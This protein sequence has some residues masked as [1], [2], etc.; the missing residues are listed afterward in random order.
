LYAQIGDWPK[1]DVA[2]HRCIELAGTQN[3]PLSLEARGLLASVMQRQGKAL[4]G[5]A[6]ETAAIEL[7]RRSSLKHEE[8]E[9]LLKR[10][11]IQQALGHQTLAESDVKAAAALATALASWPLQIETA[12]AM[13]D[14]SLAVNAEDSVTSYRNALQLAESAG[15]REE[16]S[17][18]LAG[19]AR[20][21]QSEGQLEDAA[22]SIEKALRIVEASR[23]SLAS[24]ELQVTYFSMH[25]SW[26]ELAVDICM[27][28]DQKNPNKGYAMQA[29]AYTERARA[30]S[31]L[32]TVDSSGYN[33]TAPIAE[34][35]REAYARKQQ[36]V[37]AQQELLAGSAVHDGDVAKK[38]QQLY[39]EEEALETQM[40]SGISILGSQPADATQIQERLLEKHS[41]LLSYWVGNKHS[42][43]WAI[44]PD[45]VSVDVLP[46]RDQL[47]RVF[48]PLERMLQT[49]RPTPTSGEDIADYALEQK[50]YEAHLQLALVRAGSLLLRRI[51]RDIRTIYVVGDGC[52]LPLP[53]AALRVPHGATTSYA[54][55]MYNFFLEPS[56][57]VAVYLKQHPAPK[58]ALHVTVFA[59]PVF[60]PSDSRLAA[61]AH[62][63]PDNHH[64]LFTN[65]QRLTSSTEEARDLLRYVPVDAVTL[66]TGFDA[67]PDRVRDLSAKD[68]Y[69]LHFA[70]HTVT[71][72]GH[73]EITGI[74]LSM[75]DRQGKQQD[76]IFW[77]KDIYAL[78]LPSS[79]VIL[80]GCETD[81]RDDY[82][83]EGLN[84]LA[85]AFFFAGAHSV[86]GSLW[87]V[88]DNATSRLIET[89]YREL[90]AKH[91]RTDEA[92][93]EAQLKILANPQTKSPTAWA[94]FV[95]EGWPAVYFS[96]QNNTS[97]FQITRRP[98]EGK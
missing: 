40:R 85:Y 35:L 87:A 67:V 19:L 4:E 96:E 77:L 98:A 36:E 93:R 71:V 80:S 52:I 89:F 9:L 13:G 44:T 5:I 81:K 66:R 97:T 1:A 3:D 95:L 27:Q 72:S 50:R 63:T 58:Q 83:G 53:F 79:L 20:A 22:S 2:L 73:P 24:R 31:L 76:G 29:F 46:P 82:E 30:R 37:T 70:T 51:P 38:L 42:Y 94:P 11:S 21:L 17:R 56:A 7:A 62:S 75:W 65:L 41:A 60:S 8:A 6:E 25:K 39:Q 92:L 45:S 10:A 69:I 90:L 78:H 55:Q 57:S 86:V 23:G 33:A 54:L 15:E 16:Q 12:L 48:I 28:L 14:V 61:A 49:R 47:E 32:D 84:N 43:R 18:A 88:E 59:D 68:A 34:D 26:Y 91:R 74:A 64:L